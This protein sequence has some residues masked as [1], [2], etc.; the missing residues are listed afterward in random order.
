MLRIQ[1][2]SQEESSIKK[3]MEDYIDNDTDVVSKSNSFSDLISTQLHTNIDHF[4]EGATTHF[5]KSTSDMSSIDPQFSDDD[6][7]AYSVRE[8]S[9]Q[10]VEK[11]PLKARVF[12]AFKRIPT[13]VTIPDQHSEIKS[14]RNCSAYSI[15]NKM[16]QEPKRLSLVNVSEAFGYNTLKTEP[17]TPIKKPQSKKTK[18][19]KFSKQ[20]HPKQLFENITINTLPKINPKMPYF[21]QSEIDLDIYN[22]NSQSN[23]NQSKSDPHSENETVP[24]KKKMEE[25]EALLK[26][27]KKRVPLGKDATEMIDTPT[28]PTTTLKNKLHMKTLEM[29]F[30]TLSRKRT[31][32]IKQI[33]NNR[34]KSRAAKTPTSKKLESVANPSTVVNLELPLIRKE[35]PKQVLKFPLVKEPSTMFSQGKKE[36]RQSELMQLNKKPS[37]S[38]FS[39]G[40]LLASILPATQDKQYIRPG[41]RR[42]FDN[43]A[44]TQTLTFLISDSQP[45]F[46]I[47]SGTP[48]SKESMKRLLIDHT[49]VNQCKPTSQPSKLPFPVRLTNETPTLPPLNDSPI[50]VNIP[51]A[52]VIPCHSMELKPSKILPVLIDI[53]KQM[54][55]AQLKKN[56][57]Q[58]KTTY[59][60]EDS[61]PL[62]LYENVDITPWNL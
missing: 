55:A 20:I 59:I 27:S 57:E 26:K 36:S 29:D 43:T 40:E 56:Q 50:I 6:D 35:T 18:H 34:G 15:R 47:P 46:P 53:E 28:S 19:T 37:S 44:H 52:T 4:N 22:T 49:I 45:V 61:T 9:D 62:D 54:E 31:P 42:K 48:D 10:K 33:L 58:V 25:L 41:T 14:I 17:E 51:L 38:R 11:Q 1:G 7:Y 32:T 8:E 13:S 3:L 23:E 5:A 24:K 2:S 12:S 39:M 30:N 21:S 60:L 16:S